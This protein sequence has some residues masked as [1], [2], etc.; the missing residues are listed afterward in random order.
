MLAVLDSLPA[1]PACGNVVSLVLDLKRFNLAA[2]FGAAAMGGER[3]KADKLLAELNDVW[4]RTE[5]GSK[6]DVEYALAWSDLDSRVGQHARVALGPPS[7][8]DRIGI[9]SR[10]IEECRSH[11]PLSV[12]LGRPC[13]ILCR[14]VWVQ[15]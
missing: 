10:V 15:K 14:E 1:E 2:E 9:V 6:S 13:R 8:D 4:D 7:L 5:L 12:D 11:I 3:R